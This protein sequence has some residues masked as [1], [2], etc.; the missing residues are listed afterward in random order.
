MA[1]LVDCTGLENQHSASYPGFESLSFR[2]FKIKLLYI[3]KFYK[4][5]KPFKN[6]IIS[7]NYKFVRQP[8]IKKSNEFIL[9]TPLKKKELISY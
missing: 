8:K 9:F 1:E 2:N 5:K 6:L 7:F 3:M 4:Q